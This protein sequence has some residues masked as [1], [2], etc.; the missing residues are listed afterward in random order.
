MCRSLTPFLTL[1]PEDVDQRR[2]NLR[3]VFNAL[4][5]I[6]R[7]GAP[8]RSLPHEFPPWPIGSHQTQRW[9]A[10]G[11]FE[12]MVHDLWL[13]CT[14]LKIAAGSRH[15][16]SL[17]AARCNRPQQVGAMRAK[18]ELNSAKAARCMPPLIAFVICWR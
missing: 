11:C 13:L 2:S 12:A 18:M 10:A 8:W 6:V 9:L 1:L 16:R 5:W 3:E 4:R 17:R 14:K 15:L 7:A